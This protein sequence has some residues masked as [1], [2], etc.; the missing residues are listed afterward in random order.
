MLIEGARALVCGGA[1]GLGA[2][3]ARRLA[4]GGAHVTIADV[5]ADSGEALAAVATR[6]A[7]VLAA[8]R[9]TAGCGSP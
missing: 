1:S 2:A 3:T 9:V 7:E 4:S 5:N 8:K 6:I